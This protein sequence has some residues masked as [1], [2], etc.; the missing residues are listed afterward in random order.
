VLAIF[1]TIGAFAR[2]VRPARP[3]DAAGDAEKAA[4]PAEPRGAAL[5]LARR[6]A[7]YAVFLVPAVQL[8]V[9]LWVILFHTPH[10]PFWDEWANVKL[11]EH[12]NAGTL[13]WGD[14]WALHYY[15]HRIVLPRAI[16][17]TLVQLTHW[18]VQ[19]EML[20][21][22]GLALLTA[23]LLLACVRRTLGSRALTLALVAPLALLYFT[24]SAFSDWFQPFQIQFYLAIFGVVLALWALQRDPRGWRGFGLALVGVVIASLSSFNGLA[25]WLV[26]LP[27]I[28]GMGYRRTA[29]WI[30]AALA[31]GIPYMIGYPLGGGETGAT[32]SLGAR[33]LQDAPA[34]PGFLVAYLGAPLGYPS[35]VAS[36]IWGTAGVVVLAGAVFLSWRRDK[37][38][39]GVRI[40]IE[41]ALFV[42]ATDALTTIG[43]VEFGLSAAITSRYHL[44]AALWW[45]CLLVVLA[46]LTQ[47]ALPAMRSALA[48]PGGILAGLRAE[49]QEGMRAGASAGKTRVAAALII[50]SA[51]LALVISGASLAAN[52]AGAREGTAFQESLQAHQWCIARYET[53][54]DSCLGLWWPIG[55]KGINLAYAAY[56]RQHRYAIFFS[57]AVSS[58]SLA[59]G[60]ASATRP[61]PRATATSPLPPHVAPR[62]PAAAT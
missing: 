11:L 52:V 29:I 38:L 17:L 23:A 5:A 48:T 45:I 35:E 22:L 9:M 42:L 7:P 26:L 39:A 46:R 16:L 41:L 61:A 25:A 21:N 59:S 14:F 10:L 30:G 1:A 50:G 6:S 54:P 32:H 12:A 40:W 58:S 49:I 47:H 24:L 31:I 51:L 53:A 56:L 43:R 4:L 33:I 62:A 44:F 28:L 15:T 36:L 55:D 3:P 57:S 19:V 18:N 2:A 20:F 37:S 34:V 8:A 13:T 60:P 27:S